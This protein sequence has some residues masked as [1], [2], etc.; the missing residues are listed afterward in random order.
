MGQ[1]QCPC[2]AIRD[3]RGFLCSSTT[4]QS[5][6]SM[7][8]LARTILLA[9]VNQMCPLWR[10]CSKTCKPVEVCFVCM[11]LESKSLLSDSLL[12]EYC[13]GKCEDGVASGKSIRRSMPLMFPYLTRVGRFESAS[14]NDLC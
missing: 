13:I 2:W 5:S 1:A 9:I 3:A 4:A 8:P 7:W 12:C 6:L 14:L 11:Q 10:R